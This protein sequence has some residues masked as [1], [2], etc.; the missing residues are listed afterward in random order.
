LSRGTYGVVVYGVGSVGEDRSAF[1]NGVELKGSFVR[2]G[3]LSLIKE[4]N[5]STINEKSVAI[6]KWLFASKASDSSILL[7]NTSLIKHYTNAFFC[8]PLVTK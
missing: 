7:G 3:V 8:S 6:I 5:L 4:L 2:A 1:L